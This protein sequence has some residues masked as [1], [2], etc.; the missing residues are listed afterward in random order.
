M[1]SSHAWKWCHFT[2]LVVWT[3]FFDVLA[4]PEGAIKVSL[5]WSEVLLGFLYSVSGQLLGCLST[6]EGVSEL[7]SYL[8]MMSLYTFRGIRVLDSVALKLSPVS[9]QDR[10][11]WHIIPRMGYLNVFLDWCVYLPTPSTLKGATKLPLSREINVSLRICRHGF[12]RIEAI[13]EV[14]EGA[15]EVPSCG[16]RAHDSALSEVEG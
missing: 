3:G 13:L 15:V 9:C 4:A 7:L 2:H 8:E 14:L 1:S 12:G 16:Q 6:L 11:R 5:P 10:T